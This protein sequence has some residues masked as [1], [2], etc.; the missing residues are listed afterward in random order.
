MT[1]SF[2]RLFAAAAISLCAAS[3]AFAQDDDSVL[4]PAEPDFTLVALPTALRLPKYKSS[5]RITHR[6]Q[7][8]LKGSGIGDLFGLDAGAQVG[9]E[10][11]VGIVKNGQIGFN[12][13]GDKTIQFFGQYGVLRQG[14]SSPLEL[15]ALVSAEGTN[16]FRD[17]YSPALGAVISRRMGEVVALYIE[18]MWVNNTNTLPAQVVNSNNTVVLGI[19]GRFRIRPTVYVVAEVTPRAGG[20]KPGTNQ[21][22]LAIEKRAGGHLF[23]LNVSNGPASM[24]ASLARG[25]YSNDNWYLGFN[26]SRKFF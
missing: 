24:P 11:R 5:F 9:I 10:Y 19:G 4:K 22:S 12:R 21:A 17:S 1:R 15:S 8:P 14:K 23:Q 25:A 18:P 20:Y 13:T 6:F 3:V 16:N 2:V 7:G 26:L